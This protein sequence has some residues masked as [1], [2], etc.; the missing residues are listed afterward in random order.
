MSRVE[1]DPPQNFRRAQETATK[2]NCE[3]IIVIKLLHLKKKLDLALKSNKFLVPTWKPFAINVVKKLNFSQR[4]IKGL[5]KMISH[6]G[7]L[8]KD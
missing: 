5:L 4:V 7:H 6:R 1:Q 3:I 2:I 8:I